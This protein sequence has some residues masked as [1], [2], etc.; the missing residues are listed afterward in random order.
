MGIH[1]F[2]TALGITK[3]VAVYDPL[4]GNISYANYLNCS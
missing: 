1:G 3:D 2:F 4:Q